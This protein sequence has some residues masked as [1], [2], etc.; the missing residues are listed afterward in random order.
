MSFWFDD[1]AAS[2]Q[3]HNIKSGSFTLCMDEEINYGY[4][5]LS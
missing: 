3:G 4:L 2:K 5:A 1:Q